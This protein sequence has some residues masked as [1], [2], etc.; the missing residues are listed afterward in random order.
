[1]LK[2]REGDS[3]QSNKLLDRPQR[4]AMFLSIK[5]LFFHFLHVLPRILLCIADAS[6]CLRDK[7]TTYTEQRANHQINV[8]ADGKA[9]FGLSK[10]DET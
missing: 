5:S 1:M 7:R 6:F 3:S 8:T 9:L 4:K 2:E 10:V